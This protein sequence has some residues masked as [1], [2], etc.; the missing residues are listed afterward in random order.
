MSPANRR[1][2]LPLYARLAAY[3]VVGCTGC[4]EVVDV[5]LYEQPTTIGACTD[6]EGDSDCQALVQTP[7]LKFAGLCRDSNRSAQRILYFNDWASFVRGWQTWSRHGMRL[8]DI[9]TYE[10]RGRRYF[11]GLFHPGTDAHYLWVGVDENSFRNK[12]DELARHNLRLVDVEVYLEGGVRRYAGVWRQGTQTQHIVTYGDFRDIETVANMRREQGYGLTGVST[13]EEG[14]TLRYA[15]IWQGPASTE[16]YVAVEGLT[17]GA[18]AK[19]WLDLRSTGLHLLILTAYTSGEQRLYA[20]VYGDSTDGMELIGASS[21]AAF[22]RQKDRLAATGKQLVHIEYDPGADQPPPAF[23][24]AF[25]DALDGHAVGYSYAIAEESRLVSAAGSGYARAP[26]DPDTTPMT[27]STRLFL[28][29]VSK[30][31]TAV[32]LLRLFQDRNMS[33]DTPFAELVP[34][35]LPSEAPGLDTRITVRHLLTHKSGMAPWGG[36]T[37]TRSDPT[38]TFIESM[39]DLV[40]LDLNGTPGV[41]GRYSNGNYCLAR[42]IIEQVAGRDYVDYVQSE[43]LA[44]MGI[45]PNSMSCTPSSVSALY[46]TSDTQQPGTAWDVDDRGHCSAYGWRGSARDLAKFLIGVRSN[47]VLSEATKTLA[48]SLG[49][50]FIRAN[51]NEGPAYWHNGA[52]GWNGGNSSSAIVALPGGVDA[53]VLI[54][55]NIGAPQNLLINAFNNRTPL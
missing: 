54:N 38:A 12:L 14:G 10:R 22:A 6:A 44:P 1:H 34:D 42:V 16:P 27:D 29:S 37:Q 52:F 33:I 3:L 48:F 46:Y 36:C 35:A 39:R 20:G 55:S 30:P 9:E 31:I 13:W 51:T 32:A 23:A 40:S 7:E 8:V 21:I 2:A 45:S 5:Q 43:I 41:T 50:G 28:A 26:W 49:L 19:K 4:G 11:T 25:H 18:F 53:V 24:A 47:T 15:G 17:W